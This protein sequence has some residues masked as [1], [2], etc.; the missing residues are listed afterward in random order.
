M[1]KQPISASV[2]LSSL[3]NRNYSASHPSYLPFV[4]RLVEGMLTASMV[5]QT[6]VSAIQAH[7][8]THM[9]LVELKNEVVTLQNVVLTLNVGKESTV[10]IASAP[11]AIKETHM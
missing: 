4:R 7:R 8:V 2:C 9:R 3:V 11:L 6:D 1:I 10:L 5:Y